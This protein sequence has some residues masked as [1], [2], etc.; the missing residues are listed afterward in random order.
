MSK[1]DKEH[2][3][4]QARLDEEIFEPAPSEATSDASEPTPVEILTPEKLN[5]M[6]KGKEK[7]AAA[8]KEK[9][10]QFLRLAAEYDNFRRRS[11]KEKETLWMDAK[12]D[13]ALAFL[14]VYDNLERA[15]KQTCSDEAYAKGVDMTMTQW[16]EVLSKLGIVEIPALGETFDPKL[17]NAVMHVEDESAGEN[18][19]VEVFQ[20]GFQLGEK[21]IR[22][23]MVKVAN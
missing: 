11:Q 16:K 15:L 10:E 20:T 13:T 21:V 2:S 6:L 3:G 9:E 12:A 22:F 23:A 19:I 7:T 18:T 8:L 17:H 4:T 14:P 1:K 5:S